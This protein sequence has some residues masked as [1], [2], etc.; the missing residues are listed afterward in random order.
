MEESRNEEKAMDELAR[1]RRKEAELT[2]YRHSVASQERALESARS[3]L[4]KEQLDR[5]KEIQHELETREK[6]F[7]DRERKLFDRQR[8]VEEQLL[9]RQQESEHLRVRLEHEIVDREARLVEAMKQL[10]LEKAR[11][12]EESRKKIESKSKDYV[13][14]ALDT[15]EKKELQFHSSSQIWSVVGALSLIFGIAFFGFVTFN[16][17][18]SLPDDLT[19][20][21]VTFSAFKGIVGL[22]LFA[23]LSKY[24]YLFGN[25]YMREALKNG[26][27]RHAINFGKFYLE[28]YGAAAEW[29]QIKE[30][31][32]H[33]NIQGS[34]GF[35][36][37]EELQTDLSAFDKV[38]GAIEK[39]S[40][41]LPQFAKDKG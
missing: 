18:A 20:E 2:A 22:A 26:D 1:F 9:R 17:L 28:S 37:V 36:A 14:A 15:L 40:K 23:A 21:F 29:A 11:Y 12:T 16:S 34:K 38:T 27:R 4:K 10:E 33:W 8:E 5:E 25:S 35:G 3:K 41:V 32:E 7:V 13:I 31:F 6:F 19:W 39:I 24:S 30:A